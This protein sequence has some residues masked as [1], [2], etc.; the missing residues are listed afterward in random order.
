MS[1]AIVFCKKPVVMDLDAGTYWWCSCGRSAN[2]PW[3]DGSHKG[4]DCRPKKLEL[5]EA[6][7]VA[8]CQCKASGNGPLCDGSHKGV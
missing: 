8:L 6:K 2:S 7:R 3:C 4:T 1:D 5:G